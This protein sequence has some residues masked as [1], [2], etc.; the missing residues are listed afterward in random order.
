MRCHLG[1]WMLVV[2]W[3]GPFACSGSA[4]RGDAGPPPHENVVIGGGEDGGPTPET[5]GGGDADDVPQG[6]DLDITETPSGSEFC[7]G[8][9]DCPATRPFCLLPE[10]RCVEC[11]TTANCLAAD[12]VCVANACVERLC[13]PGSRVCFGSVLQVCDATGTSTTSE[14]CAAKGQPCL[15]GACGP[16]VPGKK[17]CEGNV[18]LEC[19]ADGLSY[20]TRDCGEQV[21]VDG[22][23]LAC[24]PGMS[25]CLGNDA[26][27]CA[28]DGSG[29]EFV[30]H[31]D[32]TQAGLVCQGGTCVSLCDK[33]A[34]ERT[35]EGCEYWPLDLDQN[36]EYEAENMQFAVIV[37]NTSDQYDA[38][39]RVE[40]ATGI[41][42]EVL[43][44]KSGLA[45]ILLDPFNVSEPGVGTFGR[46][47]KSTV[48]IV[49]YQ[50]N[51]LENVGVY[52]N[53]AS[54]LLP[55]NA[56]SKQYRVLTWRARDADLASY[57]T[58]VA[59]EEGT[60]EVRLRVTAPTQEGPGLPALP[61]GGEAVVTLE[62]FQTL[63]VKTSQACA[64]LT[65]TLIEA[66]RPVAVMGGHECA[67]VPAGGSCGGQY[68]CCDHLEDQV[69]PLKAWGKR[70]LMGRTWPRGQ[71]PD[72]IR[73]LAGVDGTVVTVSGASV[74]IPV[75]SAGQVHEFEVMEDIE[76]SS[77]QP[78]LAA[79]FLA[80]QTAPTGCN[81][82]CD[83]AF[84]F[85]KKCDGNPFGKSCDT[86]EDCCPGV[87]GIGDPA[88][89][90]AVPTEQFRKDYRFLVP[91]KYAKNYLNVLAPVSASV[92]L[93]DAPI[94]ESQFS[95]FPS[96][97]FK[98]ARLPVT[99]GVHRVSSPQKVGIVVY[100]WDQY[101]SYGYAGGMMV[102]TLY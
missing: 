57:F 24:T 7:S 83:D 87:A 100:G 18:R 44:P 78:F 42:K 1:P 60:T 92:T 56:L 2:L 21:C 33:V 9:D 40:K 36:Y 28:P 85:G 95:P 61:A 68:C 80:S 27:R 82:T 50:F 52:S 6:K 59:V 96:G 43:L 93:D 71:A 64:D 41:E 51:P 48:P 99:E 47:L 79:Q 45:I 30:E 46:R 102:N 17:R 74:T 62:R 34:G 86:D 13:E 73:V 69:F 5:T 32:P 4:G 98:V 29:W 97:Q 25:S 77:D 90:V 3:S 89:I 22:E 70:Y 65:G 23:C 35:N 53:D 67:N 14:D 10:G 19:A 81:E 76:L 66:S 72:T 31:C 37:S 15:D 84:I 54:M 26:M 11:L 88:M 16:C 91:N 58:V 39:V 20:E 75:L 55:T 63:H 12:R 8:P 49:A 38:T 101:V 94:P